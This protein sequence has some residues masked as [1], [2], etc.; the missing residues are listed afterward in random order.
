LQESSSSN[1][2]LIVRVR[3]SNDVIISRWCLWHPFT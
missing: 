2:A 1:Y 3:F